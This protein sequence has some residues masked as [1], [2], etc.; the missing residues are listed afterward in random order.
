M[1]GMKAISVLFTDLYPTT[2]FQLCSP[3]LIGLDEMLFLKSGDALRSGAVP[4]PL[5]G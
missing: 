5:R 3:I 2:S 1:S 4:E